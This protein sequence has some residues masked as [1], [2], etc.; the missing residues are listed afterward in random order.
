MKQKAWLTVSSLLSIVLFML[1]L[2]DDIMHGMEPGGLQNLFGG[3]AIMVVWLCG[4]L[5]LAER[6]SGQA[7][8][9][10]GGLPAAASSQTS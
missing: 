5:V 1:H 2:T 9:L 4:T 3:V 10:L 6:R 7:I 8:M